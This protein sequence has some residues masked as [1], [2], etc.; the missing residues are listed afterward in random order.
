VLGLPDPDRGQ[1]VVAAVV[2]EN[3]TSVTADELRLSLRA[4]LSTFKVPSSFV[5]MS[6]DEIPWTPSFKVR[7]GKLAEILAERIDGFKA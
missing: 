7:Y 3:G 1:V 5:F 4:R 2:L 6:A